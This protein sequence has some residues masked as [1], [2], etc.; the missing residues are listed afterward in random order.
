MSC[1]ARIFV[2][3]DEKFIFGSRCCRVGLWGRFN[4]L[5]YKDSL[6]SI[7]LTMVPSLLVVCLWVGVVTGVVGE[8]CGLECEDLVPR[9]R[10]RRRQREL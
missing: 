5:I 7:I 2:I 10:G 4:P 3:N 1:S 8:V 6:P 9:Q